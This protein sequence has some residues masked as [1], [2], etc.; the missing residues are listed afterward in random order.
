[1]EE[2]PV[3]N[4][5]SRFPPHFRVDFRDFRSKTE[6][7]VWSYGTPKKP[8]PE[9]EKPDPEAENPVPDLENHLYPENRVSQYPNLRVKKRGEK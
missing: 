2:K 9:A 7:P 5:F 6:V 1:M 3:R 4:D 8:D